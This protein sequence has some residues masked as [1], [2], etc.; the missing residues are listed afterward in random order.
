MTRALLV[1][2]GLAL[3]A[4]SAAAQAPSAYTPPPKGPAIGFRAYGL[5]DAQTMA[6]SDSFDAVFGDPQMTAAGGG[7]EID[8]WKHVFLRIAASR[9]RRTG[10][11]VFV[12]NGEAFDL[13]I[14]MTVTL[15]PVEAG[16]GWRF[17]TRSRFTPYAGG[18]F[19]SLGYQQVSDF[20][21]AAENVN[22]RYTGGAVFGGVDAAIW[23]GI[24]VGGEAQYR[25]I[26]A[27]DAAGTVMHEFGEKDLG[28]FT[29]RVR[30]G[31]STR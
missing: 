17:V 14:P 12:D 16:G 22:D 10:S 21:E 18:A 6:A 4:A 29:A 1:F 25:R 5:V 28:G 24:F 15:T 11:R 27:P 23:K 3:S 9:A 26:I 7:A 31:F 8:I 20:A 19:V 2:A 13:D 30:I